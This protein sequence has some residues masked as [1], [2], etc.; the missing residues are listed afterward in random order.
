[1]LKAAISILLA[2]I[3]RSRLARVRKEAPHKIIEACEVLEENTSFKEVKVNGKRSGV[4]VRFYPKEALKYFIATL[5]AYGPYLV[6][7]QA[8]K[9]YKS[10]IRIQY[11]LVDKES[12]HGPA[13][14]LRIEHMVKSLSQACFEE[15]L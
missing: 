15:L 3:E 14:T 9:A 10:I 1:V 8:T 7:S 12:A 6:S 4:T 13:E 2:P 11:L 5:K